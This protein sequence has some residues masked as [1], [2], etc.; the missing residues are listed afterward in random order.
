MGSYH[1]ISKSFHWIVG[2]MILGLLALGF[3]MTALEG[4]PFKFGLY[5]WHKSF[6]IL[7]LLLGVLRLV[8]RFYKG[9]PESLGT[10]QVWEKM[11]SKV[12]H[13]VLYLGIFAMPLTGWLMSSAGGYGVSVFGLFKMPD[14]IGKNKEL[15]GLFNQ[16][17]EILGYVILV[18]VILHL[19]GA[20]KHHLID[21]DETLQRMTWA[22]FGTVH[23]V[24]SALFFGAV[25]GYCVLAGCFTLYLKRLYLG[26]VAFAQKSDCPLCLLKNPVHCEFVRLESES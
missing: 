1:F 20:L 6:G 26:T 15:G 9:V 24:L 8:W 23:G 12:T 13:L 7:V 22:Q 11:L 4:T 3:Y 14:L 25:L 16:A 19:A 10:H 5:G 2:L 21:K 18:A 17:H